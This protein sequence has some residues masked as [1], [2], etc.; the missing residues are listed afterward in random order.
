IPNTITKVPHPEITLVKNVDINEI[1][2]AKV[3]DVLTYTVTVTNTGDVTLRDVTLKDSMEEVLY[4]IAYDGETTTLAPA[5]SF[6]MTARYMVTQ[7]DINIGIVA[8]AAEVTAKDPEN[9]E[10]S[11]RDDV[12]TKLGQNASCEVTKMASVTKIAAVEAKPGYEI[13][14][15]FTASN[16]GNTILS[17]VTFTDESGDAPKTAKA[18]ETIYPCEIKQNVMGFN[19]K[20]GEFLGYLPFEPDENGVFNSS[21][22]V[23]EQDL[24]ENDLHVG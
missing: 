13:R 4:D 11:S 2:E 20:S 19:S 17:D 18:G 15:D 23:N 22:G 12:E 7:E 6:V 16:T 9:T 21:N 3:G 1:S 5:E 10:V 14:Y 8:N 24:F